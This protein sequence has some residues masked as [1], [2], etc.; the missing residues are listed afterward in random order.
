MTTLTQRDVPDLTSISQEVV[1]SSCIDDIPVNH[2]SKDDAT[3][4]CQHTHSPKRN[5]A[6]FPWNRSQISIR[7]FSRDY[8]DQTQ[9][10][11]M[12]NEWQI[13]IYIDIP[14]VVLLN[15][16]PWRYFQQIFDCSSHVWQHRGSA[17]IISSWFIISKHIYLWICIVSNGYQWCACHHQ[18]ETAKVWCQ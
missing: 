6:I 13:G 8:V 5:M 15:Y 4:T 3:L 12:K 17:D 16:S 18:L 11:L 14:K 1:D 2:V 9:S 10:W 7:I